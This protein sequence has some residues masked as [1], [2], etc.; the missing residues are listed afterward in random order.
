MQ[1]FGVTRVEDLPMESWWN[2]Q[3]P[4]EFLRAPIGRKSSTSDMIFDLNDRD[5]AHG[6]HGL[7]GGMTGSGKSEVL[8]ALILALAVTHHPY[9]LNFA[10]IDFKGGA[11][12]NELA[13]LPHTVG[14]VT[15]I[16]S[17]ATFAERVIQALSG[18]IEHRK[19]VLENA[20]AAFRFGRSHIDEYRNLR[21][22]RPLPRLVIVFDEFAEFKQRN[23][24]ESK[25]LISIARQGRSLGVHLILATQNIEAAVDPE[26][27]QNTTFRICLKVSEPQDSIQ[28]IGIPDAINLNRGRAYFSA[29]TRVLY[30]SAY[31]GATYIS[32]DSSL[33]NAMTRVLPDGRRE[34]VDA[35]RWGAPV[36][37]DS[38][39][40][41]T[42]ASAVVEYINEVS[43]KL[44]LKKPP[45]VWPDA[46][47][48][49]LTLPDL[50][51]DHVT[52]GWNGADWAP[53]RQWGAQE[54]YSETVHPVIGLYDLPIQQRQV[55]FQIDP[56]S[57]G[58]LL[59]FGSSGSGKSTLLRTM[60]TSLALTQTPAEAWVYILDFG[61]QSAL[62]VLEPF[63]HVGAVVTRLE[64]E[65]AER[66]I[67]FVR[68]EVMRRNN[69]MREA[70]VDNWTDYN[71][72]V[73][74]EQK[75]PSLYLIIDGFPQFRQAFETDF[76]NSVT[77][78]VSGGQ[79]SGLFL[80]A[81]SPLQSDIPNDLFANIQMRLTFN[82]ADATEYYRLAGQP[83]EAK[84]A[85]DAAK[86]VRPGRGLLRGTPP[87]E[88]QAAL[89]THGG[90]DKD[91]IENL[92]HLGETM[93]Q[94]WARINGKKPSE[95]KTLPFLV[96]LPAS[97]QNYLHAKASS[98]MWSM[99]GQDFETLD[100][101]GFD[102]NND[103][104]AFLIGGV[105]QQTGKTALLTTWILGLTETYSP[106]RLKLLLVDFHTRS[107]LPLRG[108]PHVS[109]Y[110][111]N[112]S[113]LAAAL[114]TLSNEIQ[115]RQESIDQAWDDAPDTFDHRK[116]L[117]QWP[118]WLVVI[119]DYERFR[120]KAEG[121]HQQLADCLQRGGELGLTSWLPANWP[122]YRK[123]MKILLSPVF[124]D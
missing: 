38:G 6:P 52:G 95:I 5:G 89:P 32:H 29:N 85:E 27:L 55:V 73:K 30:Q 46:L 119:D 115:Q 83:S 122:N 9:D 114:L 11:A 77:G 17:N 50:L 68:S 65:R 51:K 92:V 40:P 105:A 49:R 61:G 74:P 4:F 121:E 42:E 14:V 79:A 99:I 63:P 107:M 90:T 20:R 12:F 47:P 22:R 35:P 33:P 31:S 13:K 16:E 28:M 116:I 15:D 118:T 57:G 94:A 7:L 1:L 53:C 41:S 84:L 100:P 78:L 87:I 106:K 37:N 59:I 60:V 112:R 81:A 102:L 62:K 44:H 124:A 69:L 24:I 39:Q 109:D 104:P 36:L 19:R 108:L 64:L 93:G 10:L 70:K 86:G 98:S 66:L 75:L 48:E 97:G 110:I 111:G 26:I 25:K 101:T 2:N 103:G 18:E 120:L 67:H 88:F 82:Q 54:N 123:I 56:E 71:E 80:I 96:T 43:R 23:P 3:S 45:A 76:I 72:K 21:V 34:T 117:S 8:K 58:H 91:Q 113:G